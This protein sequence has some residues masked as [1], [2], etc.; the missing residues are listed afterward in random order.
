[1]PR[2]PRQ[3]EIVFVPA[4]APVVEHARTVTAT[5]YDQHEGWIRFYDENGDVVYMC[6]AGVVWSIRLRPDS[7]AA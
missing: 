2:E 7:K 4:T 1:M 3:Y 6:A 5:G